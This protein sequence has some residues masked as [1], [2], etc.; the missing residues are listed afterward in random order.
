MAFV[1]LHVSV[2]SVG[3]IQ[4]ETTEGQQIPYLDVWWSDGTGGAIV[5]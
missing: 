3:Q 5:I 4:L 1:W 2:C